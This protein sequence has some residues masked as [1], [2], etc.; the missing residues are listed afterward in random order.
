MVPLVPWYCNTCTHMVHTMVLQYQKMVRTTRVCTLW[1]SSTMVRTRIRS[2]TCTCTVMVLIPRY[3][4]YARPY[5]G[6]YPCTYVRTYVHE[7]PWFTTH[8]TMMVHV[9]SIQIAL[10]QTYYGRSW[11]HGTTSQDDYDPRNPRTTTEIVLREAM[12]ALGRRPTCWRG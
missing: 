1:Y 10:P 4:V 6:T 2:F 7:F 9:Y 12:E 3:T 5:H 8:S 11:Y